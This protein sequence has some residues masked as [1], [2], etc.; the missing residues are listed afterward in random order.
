M[1]DV[2]GVSTSGFHD[3]KNR[4]EQGETEREKYDRELDQAIQRIFYESMETYGSPRVHR[5]LLDEG[6]KVSEKKVANHMRDLG[7]QASTPVLFK[8][9]TN[10]NHSLRTYEN[11]VNQ[12]FD[13]EAPNQLWVTDI[14]Y[15]RTL[16]GFIYLNTIMDMFSRKII[17]YRMDDSMT[18]DLTLNTL[19]EAIALRQPG[20]ELVHHS[21]RGSQYCAQSYIN[22]LRDREIDISM[23]R[24]G[25]PYD[26]ACM[27]SF[28]GTLKK[29]YLHR[30][31]FET[32]EQAMLAIHFYMRFYNRRRKHSG[33]EYMSPNVYEVAY[34]KTNDK[35]AFAD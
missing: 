29:E 1:C 5:T 34:Q 19:K 15:I 13:V 21:D 2:L 10:S 31:V 6:Y 25:N 27:E 9:T 33:I 3:F 4:L 14:T 24:R 18:V 23:S 11:K 17:S 8:S 20:K 22:V 26:N 16:E 30:Y 12:E 32:K 7:L 35:F 28:F